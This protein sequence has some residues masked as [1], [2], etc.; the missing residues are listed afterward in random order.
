MSK[1]AMIYNSASPPEFKTFE[2]KLNEFDIKL[3]ERIIEARE[4]AKDDKQKGLREGLREDSEIFKITNEKTRYVFDLYY[5]EKTMSRKVFDWILKE[6]LVDTLLLAK[7]KKKGYEQLCCVR[8]INRK[9]FLTGDKVCICRVS[10]NGQS[11]AAK[12]K[13]KVKE[14]EGEDNAVCTLC[15]CSGC[16]SNP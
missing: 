9:E 16:P 6:K 4:L 2:G 14:G 5:I 8:C 7:W 10:T 13:K 15:G 12:K 11:K 3:K 1:P